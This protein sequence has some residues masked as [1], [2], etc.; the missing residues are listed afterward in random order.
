MRNIISILILSILAIN[1]F[2]QT[3]IYDI[4]V[5]KANGKTISLSEYRGKVML[6]VNSATHCG[7]TPQYNELEAIYEKY[8]EKGFEILDFPCNQ[9]G[10]QAP[11][12]ISEIQEFCTKFNVSFQQFDKIDV[13]G[14]NEHPL[15]AYLKSKKTFK[16]FGNDNKEMCKLMNDLLKRMHP[17]YMETS[18]IKWNFTK[19]LVDKNGNVVQRFEPTTD[20]GKVEKAIKKLCK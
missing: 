7:F 2:A 19:F 15:F 9:F 16:G 20:M 17:D 18:D 3:S 8:H 5:K 1:T 10:E 13:N 4:E 6:V 14:E 11:G 12:S